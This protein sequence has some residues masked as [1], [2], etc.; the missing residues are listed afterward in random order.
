MQN[1]SQSGVVEGLEIINPESFTDELK[2]PVT[3]SL[4]HIELH[5]LVYVIYTSGSTG[6]PKGL[7]YMQGFQ[8]D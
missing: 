4:I 5:D 7:D 6:Q 1:S 8:S 3:A 2:H